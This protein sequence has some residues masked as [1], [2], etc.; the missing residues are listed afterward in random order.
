MQW[1]LRADTSDT[2]PQGRTLC[3]RVGCCCPVPGLGR[4]PAVPAFLHEESLRVAVLGLQPRPQ[5]KA[6]GE[7]RPSLGEVHLRLFCLAVQAFL[8]WVC[9]LLV[10]FFPP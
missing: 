10:F 2:R 4:G 5:L 7:G 3:S 1:W 6:G 8:S 9:S